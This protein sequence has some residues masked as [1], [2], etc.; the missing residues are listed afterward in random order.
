M[1]MVMILATPQQDDDSVEA[2][3]DTPIPGVAEVDD[4]PIAGVDAAN[5]NT[6]IRTRGTEPK[7]N[8]NPKSPKLN[9]R[10]PMGPSAKPMTT[11][12][13]LRTTP[14]PKTAMKPIDSLV[15]QW[16]MDAKYGP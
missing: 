5:D 9:K 16:Q 12:A 4:A 2:D 3:A 1:M 13:M 11:M 7:K 14:R 15:I 10:R 8:M 6:E